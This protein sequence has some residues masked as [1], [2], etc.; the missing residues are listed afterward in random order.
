MKS[1]LFRGASGAASI[2]LLVAATAVALVARPIYAAE[3]TKEDASAATAASA[4]QES[5]GNMTEDAMI[6]TK[7]KAAFVKDQAVPALK[8]KVTTNNG[9]VQLSG[10]VGSAQEAERAAEVARQ[11]PGVKDVKSDIQ[12]KPDMGQ[13]K[14]KEPS[15][16]KS[17]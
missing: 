12:L 9:I 10:F 2:T 7:V 13:E 5:K 16:E 11:V 1:S 8:I 6:T 4:S 15:K 14:Q 3:Q 17:Y